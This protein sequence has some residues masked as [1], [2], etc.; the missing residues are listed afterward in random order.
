VPLDG[1]GRASTTRPL[2]VRVPTVPSTT[3]LSVRAN[4]R[5]RK[6]S[7]EIAIRPRSLCVA[8]LPQWMT[9]HFARVQ[10]SDF[11]NGR[12]VGWDRSSV[13]LR[14]SVP[15]ARRSRTQKRSLEANECAGSLPRTSR[16]STE[17][18]ANA[19]AQPRRERNICAS[20]VL[21][22]KQR[23]PTDMRTRTRF[24]NSRRRK[25]LARSGRK[26]RTSRTTSFLD[27]SST[28][29]V[30]PLEPFASSR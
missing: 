25:G 10:P 30:N 18:C 8:S 29:G 20:S 3:L 28:C 4:M 9:A 24:A 2:G 19:G 26:R 12:T 6:R 22:C 5:T 7:A 11:S 21:A 16:A 17:S 13:S 23:C 14:P 1:H 27:Y 15:I